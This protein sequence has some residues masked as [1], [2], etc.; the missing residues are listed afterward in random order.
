MLYELH[1]RGFEDVDD[2]L[3]WNPTLLALR[4]ELERDFLARLKDA[5]VPPEHNHPFAESLFA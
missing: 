4:S 3:E 5:Y 2:D 1:Y